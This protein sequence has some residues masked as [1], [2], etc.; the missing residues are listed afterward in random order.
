MKFM[1][2][3]IAIYV[4]LLAIIIGGAPYF[5]GYL[6]ETKFQDVVRVASEFDSMN[7]QVVEY[8]RGWR[9]SMAKTRV[10]L[11]GKYLQKFMSAI[12]TPNTNPG[13]RT[14]TI[15]LEHEIRHGPFVQLR[16]GNYKDWAF[17][18]ATFHS[19]LFLTDEAKKLLTAEIG[20]PNLLAMDGEIT[21]EGAVKATV[22]G[23]PIKIKQ[24]DKEVTL[25][26]G[27]HGEWSVTKDMKHLRIETIAPGFNFEWGNKHYYGEQIIIKTERQKSPEGLWLGKSTFNLQTMKITDQQNHSIDLV[28][29]NTAGV[30]NITNGMA[31]VSGSLNLEKMTYQNKAY[32]PIN[33]TLTINNLDPQIVKILLDNAQKTLMGEAPSQSN[34]QLI[35]MLIPQLLKTRPQF[36]IDDFTIG[37]AQGEFKGFLHFTI[38]GPDAFQMSD[39][40]K[41]LKSIVASSN[42]LIPKPLLR[43]VLTYQYTDRLRSQNVPAQLTEEQ[44][45]QQVSREVDESIAKQLRD[46][47]IVD[48]GNNYLIEVGVENGVFT[49]NGKT[50]Q[51]PMSPVVQPPAVMPASPTTVVQ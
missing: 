21:I 33:G 17:A 37:T 51:N 46:G 3:K 8:K 4:V 49:V 10:T 28:A 48:Q 1:N 5:T 15:M 6:V 38:G 34:S 42:M 26:Q 18:L 22:V 9:K 32:G 29:L 14:L 7:V 30:L 24:A 25:W 43:E 45:N 20:D 12:Q 41:V 39:M 44:I 31:E 19:S 27:V 35:A 16:D 50:M 2:R 11:Q 40:L 47:I 36:N 13:Q 23:K